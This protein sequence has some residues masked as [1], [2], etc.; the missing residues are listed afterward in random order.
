LAGVSAAT[1]IIRS[2][3]TTIGAECS[4]RC[5]VLHRD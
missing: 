3:D 4:V 1:G 2:T 5:L